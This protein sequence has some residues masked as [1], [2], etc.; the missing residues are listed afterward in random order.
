MFYLKYTKKNMK[1]KFVHELEN[2]VEKSMNMK[3]DQ[4]KF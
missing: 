4:H 1:M 2:W 3:F